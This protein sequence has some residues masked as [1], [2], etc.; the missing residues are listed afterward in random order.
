MIVSP[1]CLTEKM[2]RCSSVLEAGWRSRQEWL[3]DA[4]ST[5]CAHKRAKRRSLNLKAYSPPLQTL[6]PSSRS[7]SERL[8]AF[9]DRV[10]CT[11]AAPLVHSAWVLLAEGYPPDAIIQMWR[12]RGHPK[13]CGQPHGPR[14]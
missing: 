4:T 2:L 8:S 11:A 12:A 3:G 9:R 7:S 6:A 13:T 5:A 10:L 14:F 1:Q